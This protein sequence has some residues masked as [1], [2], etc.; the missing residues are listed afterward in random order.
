MT[1]PAVYLETS[2]VG[3]AT[4]RPSRDVVVAGRQQITREWLDLC[5]QAYDLFVSQLV[6]SEASG[7]DEA[8][9]RQRTTFLQAIPRLG[10]T[11]AVGELAAKLVESG[12]IPRRR[13]RTPSTLPW[14]QSTA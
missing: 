8:A 14:P 12:A 9:V 7:G 13:R 1:K 4:S 10:I 2:V 3:Y 5:A 6:V 11:D